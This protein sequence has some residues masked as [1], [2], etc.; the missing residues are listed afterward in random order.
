MKA[1]RVNKKLWTTLSI[2]TLDES[3]S[4]CEPVVVSPHGACGCCTLLCIPKVL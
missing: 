2:E 1:L 3:P 4:M